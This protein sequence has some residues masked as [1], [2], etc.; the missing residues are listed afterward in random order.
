MRKILSIILAC[1]AVTLF[2]SLALAEDTKESA[3]GKGMMQGGMMGS[4]GMMM[5]KGKMMEK[6]DMCGMM[7]K[8]M[9]M[10]KS[11][12]ATTDGGVIV[13]MGNKLLKYDKDLTLQKEVEIK[14]D[15]EGM[16]KTMMQMMEKYPMS[17]KMKGEA[18][19]EAHH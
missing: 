11:I 17:E 18:G 14:M 16:Q 6:G 9:M 12:V 8:T 4:E 13:L 1:L 15:M 10:G 19:H 5:E 3:M 2:C 7:A